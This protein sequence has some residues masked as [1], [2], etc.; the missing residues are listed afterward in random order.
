MRVSLKKHLG[1]VSSS[2]G[3]VGGGLEVGESS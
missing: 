1:E 2:E 3:C